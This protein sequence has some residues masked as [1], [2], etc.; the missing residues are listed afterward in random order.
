MFNRRKEERMKLA[1]S[2]FLFE[3]RYDSQSLS[4]AAFCANAG[5]WGY[6]GVELR[7][8]QVSPRT[9]RRERMQLLRIVRDHGLSVLCLTTRGMPAEGPARDEFFDRYLEL[10]VDLECTLLKTS[11]ETE[12][13]RAAAEQAK[14]AGVTVASNN[15]INSPL[16]TVA[17]TWAFFASVNHSNFRLLYDSLHLM[18][19]GEDYLDCI[20][21]FAPITANVLAQSRKIDANG[22]PQ[23]VLPGTAGSQDWPAIV[24]RFKECGYNGWITVIE[25]G[26]PVEERENVARENADYFRSLITEK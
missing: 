17:G 22:T 24:A 9:P 20:P 6:E 2:G 23:R 12:W 18:Q 7:R 25:N 11:G 10:C 26:W 19:K 5:N 3:D 1:L 21:E 13:A 16:E 15:H 8:T 14:T 4:F